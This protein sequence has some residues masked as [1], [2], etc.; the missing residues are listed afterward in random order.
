MCIE[1]FSRA[2]GRTQTVF[3]VCAVGDI[4]ERSATTCRRTPM[5]AVVHVTIRERVAHVR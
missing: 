5:V 2:S 4:A 3:S 1:L